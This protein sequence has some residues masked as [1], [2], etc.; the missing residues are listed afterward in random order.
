MRTNGKTTRLLQ[1]ASCPFSEFMLDRDLLGIQDI[2]NTTWVKT[3]NYME[4]LCTKLGF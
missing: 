3:V 1:W 4:K 2:A